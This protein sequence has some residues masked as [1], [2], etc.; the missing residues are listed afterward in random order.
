MN[1]NTKPAACAVAFAL[2][3]SSI[4]SPG[5]TFAIVQDRLPSAHREADA[6]K[7]IPDFARNRVL[8]R[9][10]PNLLTGAG[11]DLIAEAGARDGREL[12][13]TGVHVVELP[14][15][16]D[17]ETFVKVL[18]S[19]PEVEF[20]ELDRLV[21][22]ADLIPNDPWYANWEWHLRKIQG[23]AAWSMNAGSSNVVIAIL[24]TGVDA[25]HE[26]LDSKMVAGWNIYDNNSDTRDVNGHGTL[27]AGTAAASSNNAVGVASVAWGCRIMPVRISDTTGYAYFSNMASGLTWAADH[28][29]RVA[30]ISY[31][32]STSSTVATA[33]QYFQNRGGVVTIAAGNEGV[34][35][36]STD[37]P[38]ALT[39]GGTDPNDLLYPWSN[40]G[41]NLDLAAPGSAY[42]TVRGG[43]YSTAS[44]TSIAAPIVAGVAALVLSANPNLTGDEAQ[45]ILKQ[46]ADD[47]GPLGWD[48]GYGWGRVNAARAVAIASG[49]TPDT[50]PPTVSFVTPTSGATVSGTISVQV[51][52]GD[53][54]GVASVSLS[55]DGATFGTDTAA[56]Y[57][58][59]WNTLTSLNGLHTLTTI[60]RDGAGNV[61]NSSITVAVDN[62]SDTTPPTINIVSPTNGARVT[63]TVSVLVNATDQV[64]VVKVE[65]YVDGALTSSGTSAPFTTRWNAKR[66]RTGTHSL[67]C[68]AYDGAGNVGMSPITTV[69][70]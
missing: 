54:V 18:Q 52:A 8:V 60:A 31:R 67:Q 36:Q 49:G 27:V 68:K 51:A 58:F 2:M 55:L 6:A 19:R 15:G 21:P 26:D 63:N 33:A 23:P 34:F 70:K 38:Y 17:E 28:G 44:G 42:T 24:D 66:A 65:L 13:G 50:T 7:L 57:N 39:V 16:A 29:A 14:A 12:E 43:G 11:P 61:A 45:T 3:F 32:A 25:A 59:Q 47:F 9:F 5:N 56:P 48:S 64:G 41:N 37:N 20:A 62:T 30:N 1:K 35:E 53:N 22:P 46:S 10:R 69:Y 40:S 4:I